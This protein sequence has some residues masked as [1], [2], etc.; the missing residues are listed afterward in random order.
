MNEPFQ[1]PSE[2]GNG[3]AIPSYF[4][5]FKFHFN[6]EDTAGKLSGGEGEIAA[7]DYTRALTNLNSFFC[8]QPGRV[9]SLQFEDITNQRIVKPA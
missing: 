3:P 9:I 7:M 6:F 5:K 2:R 4:R 1:L 8:N